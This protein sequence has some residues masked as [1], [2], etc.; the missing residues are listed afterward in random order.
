MIGSKDAAKNSV[1]DLLKYSSSQGA[2]INAIDGIGDPKGE[3]QLEV[4]KSLGWRWPLVTICGLSLTAAIIGWVIVSDIQAKTTI[5][6]TEIQVL[7]K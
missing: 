1:R 2:V 3:K 5:R 7:H 6:V 4:M